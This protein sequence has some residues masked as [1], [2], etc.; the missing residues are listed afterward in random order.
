MAGKKN[1]GK[2]KD[3]DLDVKKTGRASA[4]DQS[5][6]LKDAELNKVAG[7]MARLRTITCD[8]ECDSYACETAVGCA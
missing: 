5:G 3:L 2:S 1:K 8:D 6:E 4:K 7:G